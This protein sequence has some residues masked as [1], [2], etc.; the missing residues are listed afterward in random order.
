V[1]IRRAEKFQVQTLNNISARGIELFSPNFYDVNSEHE[2]PHAI[3]V[4]SANLLEMSPGSNLLVVGR[5]GAGTNNI[6]TEKLTSLGIPVFN[7]PGANANAVKELVLAGLLMSARNIP[8]SIEFVGALDATSNNFSELVEGGKKKFAG[9]ELPGKTL[10][11]IGLGMIGSL[12]ADVALK[13]G[14]RVIGFDPGITIEAAWSLPAGVTKASSVEDLA[15]KSDFVTLHVPLNESTRNLVNQ[16]LL[17]KMRKDSV[18]LNFSRGGVVD[19][20]AISEAIDAG[21]IRQYICDFPNPSLL[22]VRDV[23]SLPHLGASTKEAEENCALMIASQII[24]Y[25]DNGNVVNSVNFPRALMPRE[26]DFRLAIINANVPNMLG[27]ISTALAEQGLNIH[28]MINNSSKD[29]ALTLVDV[30]SPISNTTLET[31]KGIE[32]VRSLRY[33]PRA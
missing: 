19:N 22:G 18:V 32:G 4:R 14:M 2:N 30:D 3:L 29:I 11:V 21:R 26:S 9:F 10:G 5:A 25:L 13:L 33:L 31:I 7:T 6:P 23:I 20:G 27:Q 15:K 16:E 17:S 24:D 28:N 12:V 1:I 8:Q